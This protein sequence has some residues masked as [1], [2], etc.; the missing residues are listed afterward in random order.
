M[1]LS[2]HLLIDTSRSMGYG[3]PL[4]K[5]Q[6]ARRVA[7]ALG[8]VGLRE[9]DRVTLSAFAD[10]LA[11]RMPALRG[12]PNIPRF[13]H[14][15]DSIVEAPGPPGFGRAL[16]QYAER[17][18]SPGLAIVISDFFDATYA[19]GVKAL[20]SKALPGRARSCSRPRR[21]RTNRDWR[22]SVDRL[23]ER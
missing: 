10:G 8:F 9:F 15:L 18:T 6:Y 5:L 23:R 1:D 2:V 17:E 14:F 7:A 20:L 12:E 13:L 19:S 3:E 22:R 21:C 11:E 4:T 16:R